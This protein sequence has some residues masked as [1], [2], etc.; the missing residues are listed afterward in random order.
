VVVSTLDGVGNRD[1][2]GVALYMAASHCRKL[3]IWNLGVK[4]S[5][6]QMVNKKRHVVKM[7]TFEIEK[8]VVDMAFSPDASTFAVASLDGYVHFYKVI[9]RNQ[10]VAFSKRI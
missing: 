9:P 5:H 7:F 2:N 1:S 3:R 10:Y 8:Q 4:A 6:L